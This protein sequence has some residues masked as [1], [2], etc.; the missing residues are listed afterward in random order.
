M[1]DT[2]PTGS[3]KDL[4][5]FDDLPKSE[6]SAPD[7][8]PCRLEPIVEILYTHLFTALSA[9]PGSFE[10]Q[11]RIGL[12]GGLGQGKTSALNQAIEQLRQKRLVPKRSHD[13]VALLLHTRLLPTWLLRSML[14]LQRSHLVPKR[15]LRWFIKRRKK[16]MMPQWL[17]NWLHG[18]VRCTSFDTGDYKPD[19]LEFEFDRLIGRWY[20]GLHL[21]RITLMLVLI[22]S[23]ISLPL[24]PLAVLISIIISKNLFKVWGTLISFSI[25]LPLLQKIIAFFGGVAQRWPLMKLA[26][27]DLERRLN[28]RE[29]LWD[30]LTTYVL[31][32]IFPPDVLVVDNLDRANVKQ[33]RSILRAIRKHSEKLQFPIIVVMDETELLQ[34]KPHEA[35]APEELL[36]KTILVECRMSLRM[37]DDAA[38]LVMALAAEGIE[39]NKVN[40]AAMILGDA[41]LQ[42]DWTRLFSFLPALGPR[43]IKRF[44]ND[45]LSSCA[46]LNISQPDDVAALS[47]LY[48]VYELAPELQRLG[49]QAVFAL[50]ANDP[51]A[52]DALCGSM[53]LEARA[54]A[55]KR[56]LHLTR[57]LQP[58]NGNWRRLVAKMTT[59][60][61]VLSK[62]E[63][64]QNTISSETERDRLERLSDHMRAV[65]KGYAGPFVREESRADLIEP[66]SRPDS[67]G[68]ISGDLKHKWPVVEAAL[69]AAEDPMERWR[70]MRRWQQDIP[71][72]V[73]A[74]A[75]EAPALQLLLRVWLGDAAVLDL[76]RVNDRQALFRDVYRRGFR[77]LFLLV[78]GQHLH[79]V[80]RIALASEPDSFGQRDLHSL[81]PWIAAGDLIPDPLQPEP[82]L[83]TEASEMTALVNLAWPPFH[84]EIM[85]VT[86]PDCRAELHRHL[87]V[88]RQ[89]HERGIP[90]Q[91]NS[92]QAAWFERNWL[93]QQANNVPQVLELLNH[94]LLFPIADQPDVEALAPGPQVHLLGALMLDDKDMLSP[95]LDA[96]STYDLS[97]IRDPQTW[98]IGLF[99]GLYYDHEPI[100]RRWN[101]DIL[102]RER[103]CHDLRLLEYFIRQPTS[104]IWHE[105][106]MQTESIQFLFGHALDAFDAMQLATHR[107]CADIA[108]GLH[109]RLRSR[110]D[111]GLILSALNRTPDV[112][113]RAADLFAVRPSD[114]YLV[115]LR[116][117]ANAPLLHREHTV[118]QLIG[119]SDTIEIR[120]RS[121]L[122]ATSVLL[123]HEIADQSWP[124][125]AFVHYTAPET[126]PEG[127]D[128]A[129]WEQLLR[130]IG[131]AQARTL[132]DFDELLSTYTSLDPDDEQY[133]DHF[134]VWLEFHL[135][136][137]TVDLSPSPDHQA[138]ALARLQRLAAL[139][140]D[141]FLTGEV[142]RGGQ[143]RIGLWQERR[144]T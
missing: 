98:W 37:S 25:A 28:Y 119:R 16:V 17:I 60:D 22:L 73:T 53:E 69:C 44:W 139:T 27:R 1:A 34:F 109:R 35:E 81:G 56:L 72:E 78:P 59:A 141:D 113:P 7:G 41:R 50:A 18:E 49:E 29:A 52:L 89:V 135:P 54:T 57:H 101:R 3:W 42:G 65:G 144:E 99:L 85:E 86:D 120:N 140:H 90:I 107:R 125:T 75:D 15:W 32:A 116:A 133:F 33:Q 127:G 129:L 9:E 84:H 36:R 24:F 131:E 128:R 8:D 14:A 105:E 121:L 95:F 88:L 123:G 45:L 111:Y 94:L 74:L 4:H 122:D 6:L 51:S 20:L 62:S 143:I 55:L 136:Y 64:G 21:R 40:P 110:R 126:I 23:L 71:N 91:P 138:V 31:E 39:L 97:R 87:T 46:E 80:D 13:W 102:E 137:L 63:G 26:F 92:L 132:S 67:I 112:P 118:R 114:D 93:N 104:L 134:Y 100:C 58:L 106:V 117:M 12:F 79:V 5:L 11:V 103:S 124:F 2:P 30:I 38:L 70:I 61:K 83:D 66:E 76:M 48:A 43:R 108:Q 19:V 77:S 82:L 10:R 115:H 96:V 47:R 130:S 142:M 68:S